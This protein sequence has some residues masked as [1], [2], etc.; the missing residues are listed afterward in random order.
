MESE[1]GAGRGR[2]GGRAS[3]R[4]VCAHEVACAKCVCVCVRAGVCIW[5]HGSRGGRSHKRALFVVYVYM[6]ARAG[7][8]LALE[9]GCARCGAFSVP[10]TRTHART[11][12]THARTRARTHARAGAHTTEE[13]EGLPAFQR[14]LE[15]NG[16]EFPD[17]FVITLHGTSACTCALY[18][19][20]WLRL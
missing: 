20:V 17:S 19:R 9:W 2:A 7:T 3:C 1:E 18:T 10:L 6:C 8:A 14:A 5:N 13:N 12:R 16:A 11:A 4:V 15:S